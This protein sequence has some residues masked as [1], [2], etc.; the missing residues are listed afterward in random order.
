MK[1]VQ[2]SRSAFL[3]ARICGIHICQESVTVAGDNHVFGLF[4]SVSLRKTLAWMLAWMVSFVKEEEALL[5]FFSPA[6]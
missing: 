1:L 5:A 3:S 6:A 4:W 2:K